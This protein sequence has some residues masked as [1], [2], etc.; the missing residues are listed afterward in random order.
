MVLLLLS[1]LVN[2]V[3]ELGAL[4]LPLLV[5]AS[6]QDIGRVINPTWRSSV[7]KTFEFTC[8]GEKDVTGL[9]LSNERYNRA[10]AVDSQ[11]LDLREASENSKVKRD[12]S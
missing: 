5:L 10:R 8:S 12:N 1:E 3:L 6:Y 9:L 7:L 11:A 4:S 2:M